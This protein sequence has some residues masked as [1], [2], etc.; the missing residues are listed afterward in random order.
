MKARQ[1]EPRYYPKAEEVMHITRGQAKSHHP[2][3]K[4]VWVYWENEQMPIYIGQIMEHNKKVNPEY[5]FRLLN[6]DTYRSYLPDIVF[7]D[8]MPVANKTDVIR[9][10]LLYR[11]GGIWMDATI[12]LRDS[13]DWIHETNKDNQNELI[14]FYRDNDTVDYTYPVVETYFM[15][16]P[17]KSL[18]VKHW[19]EL[20]G[21][22]TEMGSERFYKSLLKRP[23]FEEIRQHIPNPSYLLVYLAGQAACREYPDYHI[24]LKKAEDSALFL[25]EC[26]R[27]NYMMNYAICRMKNPMHHLPIIKLCSGDRMFVHVFQK[28]GLVKKNSLIGFFTNTQNIA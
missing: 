21:G 26:Y 15:A 12:I 1:F 16:A 2:I 19:I 10:E 3:P 5:E 23:D 24:Y 13:L 11:Y 14:G 27:N 18:F 28:L 25:Q 22:I 20:F 17:M 4:L 6:K 8:N 7:E 9:L